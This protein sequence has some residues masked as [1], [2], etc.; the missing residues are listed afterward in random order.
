MIVDGDLGLVAAL[1]RTVED[2]FLVRR[3]ALTVQS[4]LDHALALELLARQ[5]ADVQFT[6]QRLR[7]ALLVLA[8]DDDAVVV[9][10]AQ[11]LDFAVGPLNSLERRAVQAR[12]ERACAHFILASVGVEDDQR[13][14]VFV[15]E[16]DEVGV[17]DRQD[18]PVVA[19]RERNLLVE[20][21][22]ADVQLGLERRG[23]PIELRVVIE[24]ERQVSDGVRHVLGDGAAAG[25]GRVRTRG[26]GNARRRRR[27]LR[28]E[29]AV[30]AV[31]IG[32]MH[33]VMVV[34]L[35]ESVQRFVMGSFTIHVLLRYAT[36]CR[37]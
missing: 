25:H 29:R 30:H 31:A 6:L 17:G 15:V 26:H 35:S 32:R 27:V 21:V 2:H 1:L 9:E 14:L 5:V 8:D 33:R 28:R 34:M 36:V 18:S 10:D 11:V 22:I 37:C 7:R 23:Q 24:R 13:A 20:L 19:L 4:A 3:H 12:G 16:Q